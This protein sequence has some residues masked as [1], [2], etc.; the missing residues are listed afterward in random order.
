ML[1]IR[2]YSLFNPQLLQVVVSFCNSLPHDLC[3]PSTQSPTTRPKPTAIKPNALQEFGTQNK[4]THTPCTN[5][6]MAP[7]AC[8]QNHSQT[9]D[10]S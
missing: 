10:K 8:Y 3:T 2:R 4:H 6:I 5:L 1:W 9:I 7:A